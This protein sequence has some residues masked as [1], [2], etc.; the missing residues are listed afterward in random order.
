[1]KWGGVSWRIIEGLSGV[2]FFRVVTITIFVV[3]VYSFFPIE[4]C[5]SFQQKC[6][7]QCSSRLA[8]RSHEFLFP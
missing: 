7:G 3:S 8:V 2:Y 6:V 5:F 4:F 1:M